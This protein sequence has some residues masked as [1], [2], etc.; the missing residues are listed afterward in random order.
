M[1]TAYESS[2]NLSNQHDNQ[3]QPEASDGPLVT[4]ITLNRDCEIASGKRRNS[5]SKAY[6]DSNSGNRVKRTELD[7]NRDQSK[8]IIDADGL[9]HPSKGTPSRINEGP[10]QTENRLKKMCDAVKTLL[11]CMGEDPDREGL[12]ATP[13]RYAKVLL[14][15]TQGYQVNVESL[16]NNALFHEGHDEMV[17]VKDIE[18]YS[19]CE[20]HLVPFTGR[21]CLNRSSYC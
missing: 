1:A 15:L 2:R 17:I 16:V 19:L 4:S 14:F 6:R 11:E 12:L 10:E 5:L 21:V 8:A 9:C 20:H 18:I 7:F 3:N 13:L